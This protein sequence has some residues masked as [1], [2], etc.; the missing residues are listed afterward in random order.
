MGPGGC[1]APA[2]SQF[3]EPIDSSG[4]PSL[5]CSS[6]VTF[7][8]VCAFPAS[9]RQIRSLLTPTLRL[10]IWVL[11]RRLLATVMPVPSV[12]LLESD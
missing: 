6:T 4:K 7:S 3:V 8:F 5:G 12:P 2:V 1:L 9:E 11:T 10:L